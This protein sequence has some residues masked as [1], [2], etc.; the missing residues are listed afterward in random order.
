VTLYDR[1]ESRYVAEF[2]GETNLLPGAILP[3]GAAQVF[4]QRIPLA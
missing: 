2:I 3:N 1:P 4:G